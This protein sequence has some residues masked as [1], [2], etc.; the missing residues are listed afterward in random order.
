VISSAKAIKSRVEDDPTASK[1]T[2][3]NSAGFDSYFIDGAELTFQPD[4]TLFFDDGNSPDGFP[5]VALF[6]IF[7]YATSSYDYGMNVLQADGPLGGFGDYQFILT[8]Q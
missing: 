8:K 6:Q 1:F 2:V 4:G 5:V 7:E 3:T